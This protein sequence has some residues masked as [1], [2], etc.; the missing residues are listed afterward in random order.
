MNIYIDFFS[1]LPQ[2]FGVKFHGGGNYTRN[3]IKQL[4]CLDNKHIQVILLCPEGF[5]PSKENEPEL[6]Q[7]KNLIWKNIKD[8]SKDVEFEN[9][10]ILFY[11]MLG[12]LKDLKAIVKIRKK[13]PEL[14]I[15]ATLHDVRF[16]HYTVD[17]TERYYK[18][19]LKRFFFPI[20]SFLVD[21]IIKKILKRPALRRCLQSLNEVYTV[22][23][24]SMQHILSEVKNTK[25]SWYYQAVNVKKILVN[26]KNKYSNYIL[27]V[28]G[29]R[30]LKNLSHA[31]LGFSQYKKEYP[32]SD[33]TLV[34]TGVDEVTFNNLCY[35]P[36]LDKKIIKNSTVLF[37][38]VSSEKLA[39]LYANCRFVLF[40]SKNEGFGLPVL[41]AALYG[42]T[43]IASNVTSIPEII[44][45]AV[46]YVSP[47]DDNAIAR[48]IAYLCD[49]T[50]LKIYE[51]RIADAMVIIKQRMILE[52]KYFI[53]DLI[54]I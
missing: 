45:A 43:C 2:K 49:D 29:S 48:E 52:Q 30:P 4:L 32:R 39:E 27:F 38:Y 13:Y 44:G 36:N 50:K 54:E 33:L 6:Y 16:L 47:T 9:E 21:N 51:K 28:S 12:Y 25:I 31:L 37:D 19:G 3:I 1:A 5:I 20:Q 11:P 41:E 26:E 7:Y 22:S 18:R 15:C 10:S 8:I 17:Y 53:E 23:N 24:Y 35:L 34:I 46:R 42:K 14:K 40:T